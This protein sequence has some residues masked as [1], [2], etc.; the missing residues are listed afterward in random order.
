MLS[1]QIREKPVI[2]AL[3][4]QHE[5]AVLD[6]S[7]YLGEFSLTIDPGKIVDVCRFLKRD[8]SFGRLSG[9]TGVDRYPAEP[10]FE[11]VYFLHSLDRN[12]RLRLKCLLPGQEPSIDS[13]VPV[14]KGADWYERETFDLFGITFRNHPNL[15]RIMMP[16]GWIGHPLRKDYPKHGSRYSYVDE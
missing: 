2:A 6:G 5:A 12:E 16:E 14:W 13:V 15:T 7:S 8:Q 4:G 3:L 9:I 1:D 11:L 10:R